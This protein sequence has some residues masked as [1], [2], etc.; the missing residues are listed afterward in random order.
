VPWC[1]AYRQRQLAKQFIAEATLTRSG[2]G[3]GSGPVQERLSIRW[4]G[5]DEPDA[6]IAERVEE[7]QEAARRLLA[8]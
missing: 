8:A 5:N 7:T 6:T 4:V 1:S 2:K 3:R